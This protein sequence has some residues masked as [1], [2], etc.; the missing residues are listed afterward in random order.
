MLAQEALIALNKA[1]RLQPQ[2]ALV[3]ALLGAVKY[4]LGSYE[5]S[6]STFFASDA[7]CGQFPTAVEHK[8]TGLV[9]C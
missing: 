7:C 1:L 8:S 6:G 4:K 5:V 2:N 3:F 9:A